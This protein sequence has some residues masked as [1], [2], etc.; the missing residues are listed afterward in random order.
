MLWSLPETISGDRSWYTPVSIPFIAGQW[1][2]LAH[3]RFFN[4]NGRV[5]NPFIAGQWSLRGARRRVCGAPRH[6]SIPFIA[7]Q[8]SLPALALA[9]AAALAVF[10]SPSLRGSGRFAIRLH[11][12]PARCR[13]FNPLH[14][15]A[16]VASLARLKGEEEDADVSIPFIAGQWSLR[17]TEP[18]LVNA[19]RVSIPF[20]A[21]QWSLHDFAVELCPYLHGV[22]IPFIAG[23]WSL[24]DHHIPLA[25][26]DLRF[27]SPSLR[28]SGR[29]ERRA[30]RLGADLSEFQSPSLRGSGRFI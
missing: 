13:R 16:V 6:V 21:G 9:V 2:L 17:V 4:L 12:R 10:Q 25:R 8:W 5:S 29:F 15:G 7:G 14:C 30:A 24:P 3:Y 11:G 19:I 23:Q 26:D 28:G 1:S 22:S 18:D 27:Q 20:I